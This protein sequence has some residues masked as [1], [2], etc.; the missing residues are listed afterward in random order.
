MS[1]DVTTV[2]GAAR[3]LAAE[4]LCSQ[5]R[6]ASINSKAPAATTRK[7]HKRSIWPASA[8]RCAT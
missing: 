7:P 5:G 1:F 3:I 6:T 4:Q 8:A 2:C